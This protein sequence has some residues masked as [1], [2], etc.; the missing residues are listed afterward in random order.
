MQGAGHGQDEL[1]Y[2]DFKGNAIFTDT[3]IGASHRT[4]RRGQRT[5]A[6]VFKCF[7]GR[8][9]GLL[10]HHAQSPD[11]LHA[12]LAIGD[13]PVAADDLSGMLAFIGNA[14]RIGKHE[15]FLARFGLFRQVA[16]RDGDGQVVR[17]HE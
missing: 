4:D 8:E 5:A 2:G 17:F 15:L 16:G 9:Q 3:M 14:H 6:G 13:D 11:F 7:S 12:L 10:P 1:A